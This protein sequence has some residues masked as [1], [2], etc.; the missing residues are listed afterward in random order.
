MF[1]VWGVE[2]DRSESKKVE[3][4]FKCFKRLKVVF[5]PQKI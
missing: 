4:V 3:F 5:L 1:I 2:N